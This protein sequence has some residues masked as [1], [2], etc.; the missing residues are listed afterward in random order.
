MCVCV[1]TLINVRNGILFKVKEYSILDSFTQRLE[2]FLQPRTY[3]MNY[4][5]NVLVLSLRLGT[6]KQQG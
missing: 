2:A 4:T 6:A 3:N 5:S 1:C